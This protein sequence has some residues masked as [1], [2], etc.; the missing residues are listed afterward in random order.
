MKNGT[1]KIIFKKHGHPVQM[2]I[3][4]LLRARTDEF[5]VLFHIL[6]RYEHQHAV[7]AGR[8]EAEEEQL[9]S[10]VAALGITDVMWEFV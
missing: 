5:T 3:G 6:K 7:N 9:R 10:R 4:T 2:S 1:L 8:A